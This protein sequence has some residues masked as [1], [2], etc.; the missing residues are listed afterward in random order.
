MTELVLH[1]PTA[2]LWI[3]TL[4]A[5]LIAIANTVK[6]YLEWQVFQAQMAGARL[7]AAAM[8]QQRAD[9]ARKPGGKRYGH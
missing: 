4:T 6:M 7:K 5:A 1:I 9:D 2:V 8:A 3:L